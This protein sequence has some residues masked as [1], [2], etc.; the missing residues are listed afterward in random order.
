MANHLTERPDHHCVVLTHTGALKLL[1]TVF[2]SHRS[3]LSHIDFNY[4][5]C[6][7]QRSV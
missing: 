5:M 7:F 1:L 2:S 4:V 6:V 3:L